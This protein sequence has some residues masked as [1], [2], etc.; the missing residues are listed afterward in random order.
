MLLYSD[1]NRFYLVLWV[2]GSFGLCICL[3]RVCSSRPFSYLQAF[4][5][6]ENSKVAT[7]GGGAALGVGVSAG[8]YRNSGLPRPL[9]SLFLLQNEPPVPSHSR[10]MMTVER[11]TPEALTN[12]A[13]VASPHLPLRA[14]SILLSKASKYIPRK[15]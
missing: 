8:R 6:V 11:A 4:L 9:L 14:S 15:S 3:L 5:S 7:Q 12:S 13:S 2:E 1:F 10:W